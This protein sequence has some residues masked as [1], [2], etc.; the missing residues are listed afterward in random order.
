MSW[1]Y[2]PE[3]RKMDCCKLINEISVT[4][5]LSVLGFGQH[6]DKLIIEFDTIREIDVDVKD[7]KI[8]LTFGDQHGPLV[9][10]VE[11]GCDGQ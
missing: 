5:S 7:N 1:A 8:I 6:R 2:L 3:E 11:K 10:V 9:L 4:T